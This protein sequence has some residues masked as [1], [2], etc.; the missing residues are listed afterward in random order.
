[1]YE[2]DLQLVILRFRGVVSILTCTSFFLNLVYSA[3]TRT[4]YNNYINLEEF[5]C[6]SK[7]SLYA[8]S[9]SRS[10]DDVNNVYSFYKRTKLIL[11]LA[12]FNL[13]K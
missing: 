4:V 11:A 2:E 10:F 9:S 13:C 1:M 5:I 6:K 12:Q 3:L 7:R 8:D